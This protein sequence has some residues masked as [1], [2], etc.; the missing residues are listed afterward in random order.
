MA[1]L[2]AVALTIALAGRAAGA[3][4]CS[5]TVVSRDELLAAMREEQGYNLVATTNWARFQTYVFLRLARAARARDSSGRKPILIRAE[6][7][8]WNYVAVAGL[9]PDSAPLGTRRAHDLGQDMQLDY[10]PAHVLSDVRRG[11]QPV[12]AMNVRISWPPG[13]RVPTSYSYRDTLSVPKLKVTSQQMIT[14]RLVDFG[15]MVLYDEIKG[16]SGR[17][18]SGLL[19]AL[20]SI[21]GEG[22][23][24]ESRMTISSDGVQVLR[25][26][27]KK[28]FSVT[29]IATVQPDGRGEKGVPNGNVALATLKARLEEPLELVYKPY[30]C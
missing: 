15:D 16:V 26:R 22:N 27:S 29:A 6:D 9:N 10:N 19:G 23:L 13:P 28:L 30:I 11:P 14:Y 20:F 17:P 7:W 12:L 18:T 8:F 24:V 25:A 5:T 4:T 3:Q 21:L 1:R 2:M